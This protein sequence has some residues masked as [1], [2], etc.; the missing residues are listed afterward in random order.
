VVKNLSANAGNSRD[1]SSIPRSERSPGKE[2]GNPTPGFLRNPMDR[3]AW[4]ATVQGLQKSQTQLSIHML[5]AN[6]TW[7][8]KYTVPGP[9]RVQRGRPQGNAFSKEIHKYCIL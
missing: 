8:L 1:V 6:V 4:Q 5:D 7:A 2:N 3:G 9:R